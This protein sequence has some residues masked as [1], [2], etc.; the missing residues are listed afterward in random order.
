MRRPTF[1]S[2]LRESEAFV[3]ALREMGSKKSP[4]SKTLVAMQ[5]KEV[6]RSFRYLRDHGVFPNSN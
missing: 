4:E 6:E 3:S 1:A 5:F 2:L